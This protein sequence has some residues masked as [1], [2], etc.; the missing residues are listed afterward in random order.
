MP[1]TPLARLTAAAA[2]LAAA[3]APAPRHQ[4]ID[5][6]RADLSHEMAA[7]L[8]RLA[9][10]LREWHEGRFRG[11]DAREATAILDDIR[12]LFLR[13][14]RL[15]AATF[16]S[17]GQLVEVIA[18]TVDLRR[19][20]IAAARAAAAD[21]PALAAAERLAPALAARSRRLVEALSARHGVRFTELVGAAAEE[22][23]RE[24][25]A[26][27][28]RGVPVVIDSADGGVAVWVPR[29]DAARWSDLLRNF[30]RNALQA[31][32]ERVEAPGAAAAD[33]DTRRGEQPA[34][35][36]RLRPAPS[37]GGTC[38]E[39]VDDG[40]GMTDEQVASMWRDGRSR[41][42]DGHGQGL[43]QAKRVFLEER[44]ALDV[45]SVPGVGTRI[46][47]ELPS[48]DVTFRPPR[49]L[50]SPPLVA[51]GVLVL[52]LLAIAAGQL[53][54][55]E[56]ESITVQDLHVVIALD[57]GGD[58]I[59]QRT[60]PDRVLS[61]GRSTINRPDTSMTV[62][63]P[64]LIF[65]DRQGR[66]L[67]II[68]TAP[69]RGPGL[70]TAFDKRGRVAWEHPLRWTEPLVDPGEIH[71][72]KLITVF[73]AASV[74]N[75]GGV[76]VIVIGVRDDN[77]A[78]TA[79]QFLSE[80]GRTLGEYLHPGTLEYFGSED[81]DGDGRI[82]ILLNGYNNGAR[83]APL[84]W[85]G[86]PL[87]GGVYTTCLL[88]LE[89]PTVDGQAFPGTRWATAPPAREEA[90]LLVP[91]LLEENFTK[92]EST[93]LDRLPMSRPDSTGAVRM[94]LFVADGRVY[95]LNGDL[96]PVTCGVGDNTP[97]AAL[98]PTQPVAPLLYFRDGVAEHIPLLVER[99]S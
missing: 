93:A 37:G 57:R 73:A 79:I 10:Y 59:W 44:A 67:A 71:T 4:T 18:L 65:R 86:A 77:W 74:W 48:R 41:H 85:S 95:R 21:A 35:G 16:S 60:M 51:P 36:V 38:V 61:N 32:E 99:G 45:R 92:V 88:M 11:D 68:A 34:V 91:P 87:G 2:C 84:Y 14:A 22:I 43:T 53:D 3:A 1:A 94:E 72:G 64:P 49:R 54:H 20:L 96:R 19:H 83:N 63:V 55:P 15:A 89:T 82:E 12:R 56:M 5:H 47:V 27:G 80:E 6:L 8:A 70:I 97:A 40:V 66:S 75:D 81:Y 24:A 69:Q 30:L 90:Y 76:P 39:I 50:A 7:K 62:T 13:N 26:A 9:G 23:R 17:F 28:A 25:G 46:R 42:G 52:G 33:D 29:A 78:S 98:A 31:V 58:P